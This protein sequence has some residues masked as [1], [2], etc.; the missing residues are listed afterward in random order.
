MLAT[1]GLD[2]HA[3]YVALSR[4]R[5]NVDLHY[6]RDDFA[7][8]GALIRVLSR[9]RGKD[10]ASDYAR[11]FA[12]RRAILTPEAP[13]ES[14]R[15][16]GAGLLDRAVSKSVLAAA[17]VRHARIIAEMHFSHSVGDPYT[18]HQRAEL[19]DSR[20]A[21]NA[22]Q[23][24]GALDLESAF[25][26]DL[27]LI[28]EAADGRT[29]ATVRAMQLETEMRSDPQLR[30]DVFVRRWQALDRQRRLLLR[31]REDSSASRI[32][33]TMAAMAKSLERDPQVESILRNRKHQ[34]G[35]PTTPERSIGQSLTDMLG[36]GRSRGPSTGM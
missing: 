5:D 29:Q 32:A 8:R 10:M 14:K 34:L 2:R 3:A 12:D 33:Q 19:A 30:A 21:L 16:M 27:H 17:V 35:L 28:R 36:P 9:E 15:G 23:P 7:D 4:H 31:D 24:K 1:P 13:T 20:A 26:A 25:A 22:I 6:G 18:P 11:E